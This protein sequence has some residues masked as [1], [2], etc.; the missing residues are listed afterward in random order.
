MHSISHSQMLNNTETC[1]ILSAEQGAPEQCH[2]LLCLQ[3]IQGSRPMLG[4]Y[5]LCL[6][7]LSL[8]EPPT[9]KAALFGIC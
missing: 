3:D 6:S 4:S 5:G 1:K 7:S 8:G 9:P 2:L